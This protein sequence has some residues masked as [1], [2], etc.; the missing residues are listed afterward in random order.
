MFNSNHKIQLDALTGYNKP[1]G[2]SKVNQTSRVDF[3]LGARAH[4]RYGRQAWMH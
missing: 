3:T 4:D 1:S 2:A